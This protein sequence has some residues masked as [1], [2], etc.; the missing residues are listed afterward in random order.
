MSET[1][2]GKLERVSLR[3]VWV[4]EAYDFTQWLQQNID[5]LNTALD[6]NLVNVDREQIAGSFSIDLVAEDE[7]GGTVIIE[8]QLEKSNHDHLGKLV[9]YLTGMAAKAAIWIV[10]D[11]RP[12]HIAAVAWLNETGSAAFYMVKVEAVRIGDSPAAPLFTLIVGPSEETKDVGQ[13]KKELAER[14]GIR[15]R[16]WTMLIERSA[17][18]NKLHAHITPGEYSWIGTSSGIRGLNFNYVVTQDECAAELYI[19]RGKNAAEENKAIF[20]QLF[21][22]KDEI[23]AAFGE[24]LSWERLEGKRAC[25]IRHTQPGGGYR[26]PEDQ[27][28]MLQDAI[29]KDMDRL[30]KALRPH[31]R[32]LKL[33]A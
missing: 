32:Q 33:S 23:N 30:E 5:V 15:K 17:Q 18:V 2:I 25:R 28:P 3:E 24:P 10:S 11:P 14:Y 22:H 27:W 4:H 16:W 8:N 13:T 12:E 19:D 26:S 7:G 1:S 6:L 20:D 9:T 31:L 29:I 21:A